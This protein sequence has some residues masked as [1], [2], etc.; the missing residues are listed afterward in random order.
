M[1]GI[2][3][4]VLPG[5]AIEQF[6]DYQEWLED[7]E[8][9]NY[10][11]FQEIWLFCFPD[12]EYWYS[13]TAIERKE[14][15]YRGIFLN[16]RM[17]IEQCDEPTAGV[18]V[19]IHEFAEWLLQSVDACIGALKAGTYNQLIADHL[20]IQ[21]RTGTISRKDW[22]SVFPEIQKEFFSGLSL[23][24]ID[25]SFKIH[26]R[27]QP[28]KY[29]RATHGR[30]ERE[31]LFSGVRDRIYRKSLLRRRPNTQGAVLSPR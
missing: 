27:K 24:D 26:G 22:W 1:S 19:D 29:H 15:R 30:V 17:I 23:E 28:T 5:G 12:E 21:F 31:R 14:E 10:K 13:F 4:S 11:E 25:I 7:R 16:H 18:P 3:G 20:P 6:G 9:S 8:V 2:Y